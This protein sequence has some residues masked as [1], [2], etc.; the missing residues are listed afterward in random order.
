MSKKNA[1]SKALTPISIV[2][3]IQAKK[4]A[5]ENLSIENRQGCVEYLVM[6]GY[7]AV[8]IAEIFK[9]DTRTIRRDK[10]KIRE[11][12]ALQY[13]PQ[14]AEQ[15][16][17]Q[18]VLTAEQCLY[19][20]R[21]YSRDK[22]C[23]VT[24]KIEVELGVWK[25]TKELFEKLQSVGYLPFSLQEQDSGFQD[26]PSLEELQAKLDSLKQLTTEYRP[27]PEDILAAITTI[28]AEITVI[29]IEQKIDNIAS[30]IKSDHHAKPN[31]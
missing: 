20:L 26:F 4:M 30:E 14:L 18:L 27:I 29:S 1:P 24:D 28:E 6:E 8:E 7:S 13:N 23:T 19:K 21:K 11:K 9:K 22:N 12:N 31:Q 15:F 3:D 16:L 2:R 5:P 17:G 10:Q 25:I